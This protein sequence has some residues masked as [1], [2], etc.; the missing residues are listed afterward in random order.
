MRDIFVFSKVALTVYSGVILV[1][2]AAC[3][4]AVALVS[5]DQTYIVLPVIFILGSYLAFCYGLTRRVGS[6]IIGDL[7]FIYVSFVVAYTVLPAYGFLVLNFVFPLG[8]DGLNFSI[9]NPRPEAL[10]V[11]MWRH[12]LFLVAVMF[13]YLLVRGRDSLEC[14]RMD[15]VGGGRLS[16]VMGVVIVVVSMVAI[17]LLSAPVED[18]YGHYTRFDSLPDSLRNL[19]YLFMLVKVGGYYFLLACLFNEYERCKW[20]VVLV[21][22]GIVVYEVYYSFGSRIEALSILLAAVCLY[23]HFVRS[24]GFARGALYF[25]LLGVVF[26]LV[27]LVRHV[28]FD[29]S[30][31]ALEFSSRGVKVAQEF[32]AVFY[33]SFHLYSERDRGGMPDSDWMMLFGDVINIIP[34]VDHTINNSQY[35]YAGIYFPDSVVPPQTMGPIAE[36]AIWGG[37]GDLFLRGLLNGLVYGWFARWA[38][39]RLNYI[40]VAVVYVYIYAT[41]VMALKYSFLHQFSQ[42]FKYLLPVVIVFWGGKCMKRLL[43]KGGNDFKHF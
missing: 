32:G 40:F 20:V 30:A 27:E 23:H 5:E 18:Y 8:F 24:I 39:P 38:I 43:F 31:A 13:G 17:S 37:E 4:S 6:G 3:V 22:L 14:S 26:T 41:C 21:V 12:S 25:G 11:H 33:T 34:F 10:G 36:S 29:L 35:W 19:A 1:V 7:G 42:M 28:D 2:L 16:I 15:F 9:L